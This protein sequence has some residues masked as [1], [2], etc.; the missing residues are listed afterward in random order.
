MGAFF[1]DTTTLTNGRHSIVWSVT[2]S[3]GRAD[4]I[5]SRDFIVLNGSSDVTTNA[6]WRPASAGRSALQTHS[7]GIDTVV[8][9]RNGWDPFAPL[10]NVPAD[11]S[12][13]LHVQLPARGRLELHLG[14][15]DAGYLLANETWRDLPGGSRLDTHT[16][17]FTWAPPL[18]YF[19]TYRLVFAR[20][21]RHLLVSVSVRPI[22]QAAGTGHA[23]RMY[24]DSPRPGTT[25]TGSV[26][27]AGWALDVDPALGSGIDTVHVWAQ[28]RDVPAAAPEFLGVAGL[29]VPRPDVARVFGPQF[30]Q[31]GFQLTTARL[32]PG[33]YDVT[34]FVWNRRTARWDDARTVS[35]AIR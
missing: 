29:E 18:G 4:G 2:D 26:V 23:I 25:A 11:D 27:V 8:R 24:L 7:P 34:A 33:V 35:I 13:V 21:D 19:G 5:G 30:V 12:G 3:A 20:G 1:V 16:G 10:V 14:E 31:A 6:L 32:A 17:I 22:A 28:R 9:G 15:V